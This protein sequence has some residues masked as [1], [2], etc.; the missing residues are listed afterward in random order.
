VDDADE[1]GAKGSRSGYN[2]GVT[3]AC[4]DNAGEGV[5]EGLATQR[6]N[7]ESR[8]CDEILSCFIT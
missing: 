2:G 6:V 1:D 5:V 4:D 3:V 7:G 8:C